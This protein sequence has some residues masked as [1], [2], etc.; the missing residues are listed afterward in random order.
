[1][2]LAVVLRGPGNADV[3]AE[4]QVRSGELEGSK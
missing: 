3:R 1:M 4:A 2:V